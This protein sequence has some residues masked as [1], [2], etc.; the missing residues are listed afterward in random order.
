M[1]QKGITIWQKAELEQRLLPG[2][3]PSLSVMSGRL[4]K[5]Y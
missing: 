3:L 1:H 4:N 2:E 5:D